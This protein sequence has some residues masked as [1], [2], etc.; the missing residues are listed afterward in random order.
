LPDPGLTRGIAKLLKERRPQIVHAHSWLLYSLLPL[1]PSQ[2]TRLVVWIH[3]YGF[4]CPKT[5]YIFRG[6]VCAGPGYVKCV[7]CSREQYGPT[8]ALAITTGLTAMKPTRRRVD[9]YAAVSQFTGDASQSL[10]GP[11][12]ERMDVIPNFAP[13]EAFHAFERP[14][15]SFVPREEDYLMYAGA[16]S[17]HKGLNVL[18]DAWAGLRDRPPLVLA[19]IPRF[20]TPKSFPDGVIVAENV[21]L[22]AVLHAMAHCLA[23]VVP[24]VWPDPCPSVALEAMA[25]GRPV[26]ASAVGGL[27][28]LVV[29]GKTGIHVPPADVQ[30]LRA[31]LAKIISDPELRGRLGAA[32]HERAKDYSLGSVADAWEQVFLDV[33]DQ[34]MAQP[35][36]PCA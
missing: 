29:D 1:L 36:A 3:D 22:N 14:R 17:P 9:R 8:K 24:S 23:A 28:E 12:A 4:V 6:G 5:T 26:V 16:L 2:D 18:L 19:G 20:D 34:R 31:A 10:L 13:D 25:V 32:A 33:V 30:A 21:P 15:P 11:T 7:A 35:A 27:P